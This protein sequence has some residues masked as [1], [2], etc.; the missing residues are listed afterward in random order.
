MVYLLRV[1]DNI[2]QKREMKTK[3]NYTNS[4][5]VPK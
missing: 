4:H 2:A 3:Q 5:S 1:L